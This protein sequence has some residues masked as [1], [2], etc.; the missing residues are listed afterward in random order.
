MKRQKKD[1]FKYTEE[2]VKM[3]FDKLFHNTVKDIQFPLIGQVAPGIFHIG[4]GV[5]T[6]KAGFDIFMKLLK[7]DNERYHNP[8]GTEGLAE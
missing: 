1:K 5:Y 2:N 6:T 4:E 8:D 3:S 7:G